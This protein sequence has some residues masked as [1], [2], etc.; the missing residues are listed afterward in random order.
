MAEWRGTR[1]AFR[2]DMGEHWMMTAPAFLEIMA[3]WLPHLASV[4][5]DSD[6]RTG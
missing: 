1:H 3:D 5:D 6:R 4:D 2:L